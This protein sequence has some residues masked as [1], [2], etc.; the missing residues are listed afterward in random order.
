MF[1][2]D[3]TDLRAIKSKKTRQET[4]EAWREKNLPR[5]NSLS[6]EGEEILIAGKT[7]RWTVE[8]FGDYEDANRNARRFVA[9]RIPKGNISR[10]YSWL[11][12]PSE[13]R[14]L[15]CQIQQFGSW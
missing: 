11:W 8:T 5:P 12:H 1:R 4:Y 2:K 9:Y 6:F 15:E 14:W 7:Y 13:K 3:L 10:V